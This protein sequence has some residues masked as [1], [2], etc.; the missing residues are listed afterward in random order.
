MLVK[1]PHGG[2]NSMDFTGIPGLFKLP[3]QGLSQSSFVEIEFTLASEQA[4]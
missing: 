1:I 4:N 3:P 2:Y